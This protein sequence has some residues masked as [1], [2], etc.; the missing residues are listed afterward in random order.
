MGNCLSGHTV[1]D[2]ILSRDSRPVI[3]Q[4][5]PISSSELNKPLPQVP[6]QTKTV[7]FGYDPPAWEFYANRPTDE[8]L[9]NTRYC[10]PHHSASPLTRTRITPPPAYKTWSWYDEKGFV[11]TNQ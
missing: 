7:R 1:R 2:G 8:N 10:S 4:T 3:L 9:A 6:E 5:G 11:V